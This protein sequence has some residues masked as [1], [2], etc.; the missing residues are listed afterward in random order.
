MKGSGSSGGMIYLDHNATTPCDP[1][2][3]EAMAP[4]WAED[5]GNPSSAHAMGRRAAAAVAQARN[6]LAR[7]AGCLPEDVFFTSGATESNNLVLLGLARSADI[8]KRFRIVTS[9]VEHKAVLEPCSFLAE[10]GFEIIRIPVDSDGVAD[11]DAA[12]KVINENTLLVSV[13]LANN[14][15]GVLQPVKLLV[16]MAHRHGAWMHTDAAQD[17]GKIPVDV[18]ELG[19]DFAA[20]SAH[21]MY[22]PKGVGAL[23]VASHAAR[24]ALHPVFF[25]GGQE[26]GVRPGTTNV[27]AV[28]GF[29]AACALAQER[30]LQDIR[31]IS[32]LRE[33]ME[34]NLLERIPG[35]YINGSGRDR[36]PGTISLTILGVPAD[37]LMAMTP[38]LC[39]SSGSACTSGAPGP[40]HVLL[41]MGRT[42]E[43]A[44]STIRISL[45]RENSSDQIDAA[46]VSIC[47]AALQFRS[48]NLRSLS[49]K[50][51]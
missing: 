38:D 20:F 12:R 30:L 31:Y 21:K 48:M 42:P 39:I 15:T 34:R 46:E 24:R 28:V 3:I 16:E 13:Q 14:E 26:K 25:G 32:N 5:F 18:L 2:V 1:A 11:L 45:G 6:A 4:Y 47:K 10:Q 40:S 35:A 41:A 23:Y 43:H 19:V 51:D 49:E 37:M 9:P 29:G 33:R 22:G 44:A 17:L 27:P 7:L 8:K 36:L 50:K